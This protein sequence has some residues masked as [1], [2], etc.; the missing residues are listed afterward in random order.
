M[1]G[2]FVVAQANTSRSGATPVQV[3]K[4]VKPEAGQTE[5]FHASFSGVVKIDF[6]AI[7]NEKITLFHDSKNQS[8]HIIFADGSQ[9]IIEPFFDSRGT[10]LSN[11]VLD[12]GS[13]QEF[14]GERFA[15]QFP[16]TEDVSV[17]P[18]AGPGGVASG[19]DFHGP[20]VDGLFT[21]NP[22][23]LLSPEELPGLQFTITEAPTFLEETFLEEVN[24]IPAVSGHLFGVVEEEALNRQV[25]IDFSDS[26]P[27]NE[28]THDAAGNDHDTSQFGPGSQITTQKF[29]GALAGLV[30]GGDLPITFLVN[31]AANGTTVRD[32][33]G[34]PVTSIG[35]EVHYAAVDSQNIEGRTSDNRLIFTLHV[36]TDGTFTFTLNDQIDHPTHTHDNG[37]GFGE[38]TLNLDISNA[39]IAHDATPDPIVFPT[40]T[41]EIGVIDDT[42]IAFDSAP[43]YPQP[44]VEGSGSFSSALDDEDQSHGIQNGPGDNG[45]GT[46]VSGILEILPGADNYGSVSFAAGVSVT[47]TDGVNTTSISQLQAIW[48]DGSGFG[49]KEDVT[50]TWVADGSGGG[51]LTGSTSHL[52]NAFTLTVDKFGDYTFSANAPL[53]HPFTADPGNPGSSEFEDNL[54]LVFTYTATDGDGDQVDA[55]LTINVDDDVPSLFSVTVNEVDVTVDETPGT[56]TAAD[57]FPAN[58]VLDTGLSTAIKNLFDAIGSARGVDGDVAPGALDDGA[59]SFAAST[60]SLLSIGVVNFGADGP[61]GGSAATGTTLSL[62]VTEGTYSGIQTTDGHDVFL[63]AGTGVLS[64]LILGRVGTEASATPGLDAKDPNGTV[65]FALTIDA[66]G[67]VYIADYL[68]LLNPTAGSTPAAYNDQIQLASGTVQA[69]VTLKDGDGDTVSSPGTDI[70]SHIR[71]Q[72][73]GPSVLGVNDGTGP[74]LVNNGSFEQGHIDLAGTDWSIYSSLPNPP[75]NPWTYGADHIPFEVQI[76]EPGG[77]A[78]QDGIALVELDGDTTGNGHAGQATPDPVH[79]DATIQQVI[80]GTVAGQEYELTFYYSPRPGD[81]ANNDSGLRVLWNGVEIDNIDS[82]NLPSGWQQITLHVIGTGPGDTLAFQGT[83]QEDEFGAFIDNVSLRA[84]TILD[85]EDTN[86]EPRHRGAGRPR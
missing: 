48:V 20:F 78:A 36:N 17:L 69:V 41:I 52:A 82:T 38:E 39:I 34:N 29:S 85:D 22:L 21:G 8:L 4:L 27:G 7:A 43:V 45:F 10:I 77:L 18:A 37:Q 65:A 84:V 46:S 3:I 49:H 30:T 51:T 42:P 12:M 25:E 60:G 5:I 32:E 58:D 80:A 23:D 68:P 1:N 35:L 81:S 66:S 62:K 83:G 55:H 14:N 54:S 59:L 74:N 67:K 79:T 72:D 26:G 70:S 28:D 57:P 61:F 73:D 19:A 86:S 24:Q 13:G 76:G 9:D 63:Y 2:P 44:D 6:T 33:N 64:G 31:N 50:L 75:G 16:I 15:S 56:Q 11:L 40:N 53:A 47:A 71:F